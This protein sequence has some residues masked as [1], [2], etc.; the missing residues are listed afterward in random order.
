MQLYV[1]DLVSSVVTPVKQLKAFAKPE[2]KPGEQKEVTLRV[3]VSE[4]CLIDK[5]GNPFLESGEFEIQVG[6]AS[7]C[8]L[9]KQVI[10][11]GNLSVSTLPT[12]SIKQNHINKIGTGKKIVVRGVVRDVQ[13]TPIEGVRIYSKGDKKELAVTDKKGEYLLQQVASDDILIFSKEGYVSKEIAVE[14][15]SV[16]NVRL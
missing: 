8:I 10:S 6:N 15:R 16:L 3:P 4:L 7:D 13:A 14:G 12:S 9:Q 11:V 2:L 5:D 1:R